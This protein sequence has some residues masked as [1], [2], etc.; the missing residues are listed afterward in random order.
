MKSACRSRTGSV[1]FDCAV[2]VHVGRRKAE[3]L[4]LAQKK[5]TE[6]LDSVTEVLRM[7]QIHVARHGSLHLL[8]GKNSGLESASASPPTGLAAPHP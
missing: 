8:N 7:I 5:V 3:K 6:D 1:R 4:I 2:S